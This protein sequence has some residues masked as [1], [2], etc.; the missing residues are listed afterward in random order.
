MEIERN[1]EDTESIT[2]LIYKNSTRHV[3]YFK[4]LRKGK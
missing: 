3:M 2:Y 4:A 1:E